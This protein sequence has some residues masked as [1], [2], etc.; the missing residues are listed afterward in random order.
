MNV[1]V[2]T[3]PPHPRPAK[4]Q[5]PSKRKNADPQSYRS[6]ILYEDLNTRVSVLE[7]MF[8]LSPTIQVDEAAFIQAVTGRILDLE[9][10][11]GARY[12]RPLKSKGEWDCPIKDCNRS[13]QRLDLYHRHIKT[14]EGFRHKILKRHL[15]QDTCL[16]CGHQFNS[17]T[18]LFQHER[19]AHSVEA[20]SRTQMFTPFITYIKKSTS[21]DHIILEMLTEI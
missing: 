10:H 18:G 3:S 9:H 20:L 15:D 13:Y 14:S 6:F 19:K 1:S 16:S 8:G 5:C 4:R 17:P 7:E 21:Q 2:G 11:M 12:F